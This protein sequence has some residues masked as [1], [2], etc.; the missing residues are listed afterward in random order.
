MRLFLLTL[1]NSKNIGGRARD[2]LAHPAPW[3]LHDIKTYKPPNSF[4]QLNSS[5]Y[6]SLVKQAT[7][8]TPIRG[9]T[10]VAL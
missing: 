2:P 9:D 7:F 6:S 10:V 1:Y 8:E 4:K 5:L 3:S